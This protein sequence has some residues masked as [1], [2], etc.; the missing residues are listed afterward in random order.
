MNDALQPL[1][2]CRDATEL[3]RSLMA[4][5][6]RFGAVKRLDIIGAGQRGARQ[7]MCF[8][9]MSSP[10]E[11]RALARELGIGRFGSDLV[12]VVDLQAHS[13]PMPLV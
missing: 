5:C 9:R 4:I 3:R 10:D 13:A 8:L 11:E 6:S 2:D 7:A 1:K 12:V